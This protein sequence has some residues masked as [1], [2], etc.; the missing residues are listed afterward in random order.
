MSAPQNTEELILEAARKVFARKGLEGARMQ[1][2]ADEAGIN[3]ALLHYYFRNKEKLFELI[4]QEV[5]SRFIGGMGEMLSAQIPFIKKIEMFIDGYFD[6]LIQNPFLPGFILTEIHRDPE[7]ILNFM[8]SRDI[9]V[10]L[11]ENQ[12]NKEIAA[13]NIT[14]VDPRHLI[15]NMIGLCVFPFVARP[16]LQGILFKGDP[17]LYEQFLSERKT[18]IKETIINSI[19]IQAS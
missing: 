18:V 11:I 7:M 13:G 5:L 12:V 3:K 17:K 16:I 6:L 19:K 9:P 8:K 10:H 4:F 15:V 14:R 2:I 1:E